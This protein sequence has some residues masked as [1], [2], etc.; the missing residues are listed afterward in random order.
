MRGLWIFI[1]TSHSSNLEVPEKLERKPVDNLNKG[2]KTESK[3]KPTETAKAGDEVHP[4]HLWWPLKF[5]ANSSFWWDLTLILLYHL[6]QLYNTEHC[7][8][9]KKDINNSNIF[10]IGI[11]RH[12]PLKKMKM[13]KCSIEIAL[14]IRFF[15]SK[16]G[17]RERHTQNLIP[18]L[19]VQ[20]GHQ[21]HSIIALTNIELS[22]WSGM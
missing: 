16:F 13:I 6:Y 11:V 4:S 2:N 14:E 12:S 1:S 15:S 3:T 20:Y 21:Y 10:L 17:Q 5:W 18:I 9:S 7:W 19:W 8:V 22:P